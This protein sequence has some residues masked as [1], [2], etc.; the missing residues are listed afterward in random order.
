[1]ALGELGAR[2]EQAAREGGALGCW[3]LTLEF[4]N[5][6]TQACKPSPARN[7]AAVILATLLGG[8]G[9]PQESCPNP[10]AGKANGMVINS[11]E[12]KKV[13]VASNRA[14]KLERAGCETAELD[15]DTNKRAQERCGADSVPWADDDSARA[16]R[17]RGDGTGDS[18]EWGLSA[19]SYP[20][21]ESR[22]FA[23]WQREA[24]RSGRE[25][26]G[27]PKRDRGAGTPAS[28]AIVRRPSPRKRAAIRR[29]GR[30]ERR[31]GLVKRGGFLEDVGIGRTTPSKTATPGDPL[32]Q[33]TSNTPRVCY[34]DKDSRDAHR[35]GS[36][37]ADGAD[38]SDPGQ[39]PCSPERGAAGG[40]A[41]SGDESSS[42]GGYCRKDKVG[43]WWFRVRRP[44]SNQRLVPHSDH[45]LAVRS[46]SCCRVES[47][48]CLPLGAARV[49]H[50]PVFAAPPV[51]RCSGAG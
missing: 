38:Q 50:D 27:S 25:L 36:A 3:S 2:P 6:C 45:I 46:D 19:V 12:S 51:L 8:Q 21:Q 43:C 11:A 10:Q 13:A 47:T 42:Y 23:Q 34:R 39:F 5:L 28:A 7:A 32:A 40:G 22:R 29:V 15:K 48:G 17:P 41:G 30:E 49:G 20:G 44:L 14:K 35:L 18:E 24:L 1:M 9:Q 37:N 4:T 26:E 31:A 16:K 33:T